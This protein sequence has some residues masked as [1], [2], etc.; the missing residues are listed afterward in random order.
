MVILKRYQN[1]LKAERAAAFLRDH[2]VPATVVGQYLDVTGLSRALGGGRYELVVPGRD[3][4]E[5]AVLL[6]E[7]FEAIEQLPTAEGEDLDEFAEQP[8]LTRLDPG[9][10]P[11]C[12]SCEQLLPLRNELASCPA[13]GGHVDLVQRLLDL[14]GPEVLMDCYGE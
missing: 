14:H 13:C 8:D 12:P 4:R 2:G 10:A 5:E 3:M 6:L 1:E 11:P 9:L 7:E